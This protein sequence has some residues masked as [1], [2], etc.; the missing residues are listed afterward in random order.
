MGRAPR[1]ETTHDA[2]PTAKR[3]SSIRHMLHPT[4]DVEQ[5]ESAEVAVAHCVTDF[6]QLACVDDTG[7]A[8]GNRVDEE[9]ETK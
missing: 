2:A 8:V 5:S 9:A 6:A 3:F 1:L 7:Y 4:Y